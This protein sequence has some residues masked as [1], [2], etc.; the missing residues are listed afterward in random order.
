MAGSTRQM[1]QANMIPAHQAHMHHRGMHGT[2]QILTV[3]H[4]TM[5][6]MQN[7]GPQQPMMMSPNAQ[8]PNGSL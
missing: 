3:N 1:S 5:H 7:S 4:Q 6:H 2:Q 8:N